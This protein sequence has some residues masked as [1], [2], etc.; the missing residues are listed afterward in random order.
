MSIWLCLVL[1]LCTLSLLL[2]KTS[3]MLQTS[4]AGEGSVVLPQSVVWCFFH[5]AVQL[6]C[7][8]WLPSTKDMP[9]SS[10]YWRGLQANGHLLP[11]W[12]YLQQA[13][14]FQKQTEHWRIFR[15]VYI[16]VVNKKHKPLFA[17]EM[18]CCVKATMQ[19]IFPSRDEY[20]PDDPDGIPA[21]KKRRLDKSQQLN[22][23]LY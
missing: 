12:C 22:D 5:H 8:S 1:S 21:T 6:E 13:Y 3:F 16:N 2:K 23:A 9:T 11:N 20:F 10:G 17:K 7:S 18:P 19:W 4:H 15:Q 14:W